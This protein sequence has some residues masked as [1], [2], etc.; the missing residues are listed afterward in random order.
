MKKI[1]IAFDGTHF[2][3]GAFEF[4][5]RLNDLEPV[6]LTGVFLPQTIISSMWSYAD[7]MA[8]PLMVPVFDEQ[9]RVITEQNVERFERMCKNNDI[10]YRVHK[11]DMDFALPELR[12]ETRFADLLI[13][14]SEKFY[15]NMG[16]N[17]PNE[18]LRDA[19]H[20]VECPVVLV[21]ERFVFPEKMILAYDGSSSS[22]YAIK[23]F[24]YLFPELKN[25][26]TLL[27][28]VNE[29]PEKD[30][31]DRV[32]IEELAARHFPDLTLTKLDTDPKKY[33]AAWATEEKGAMLIS[34]SYG[35]SGLSQLFKE[36][37][38]QKVIGDHQLPVFI[39]HI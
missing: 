35:R 32:R 34:G 22:V 9:E 36:S 14:G 20:G 13:L 10:D 21:P 23:Q 39:A 33:F 30:F 29:N 24:S 12:R 19:L 17:E 18:Y 7:G 31:P 11:D 38:V 6:L 37:F 16:V 5:R 2:S 4:A 8:G 27:V 25:R 15:E 26:K 28:Y 3:E 1:L